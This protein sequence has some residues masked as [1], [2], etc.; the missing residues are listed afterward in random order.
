MSDIAEHESTENAGLPAGLI[1]VTCA[2]CNGTGKHPFEVLSKLSQ[3]PV[4]QGTGH[5]EF[6]GPAVACAYC[7]GTGRQR[8][9]RMA[10]SGCGGTGVCVLAGPTYPCPQCAG[11]GREPE[12][13]LACSLCRGAGLVLV[14]TSRSG[15][16]NRKS[17]G[18]T[19][20]NTTP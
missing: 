10:C 9:T 17:P 14:A 1:Q 6:S 8:H 11:N 18:N 7:R 12:T 2:F 5:L 16:K 19:V 13:D 20:S 3:C 15:A 4:C